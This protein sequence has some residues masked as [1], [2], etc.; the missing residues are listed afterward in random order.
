MG[1]MPPT[2]DGVVLE[3]TLQDN[4]ALEDGSRPNHRRNYHCAEFGL[5][6]EHQYVNAGSE[7][8]DDGEDDNNI[9]PRHQGDG[10]NYSNDHGERFSMVVD[11]AASMMAELTTFTL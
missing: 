4:I 5:L 9:G 10:E 3:E 6:C 1:C 7:S 2:A 8:D 11:T